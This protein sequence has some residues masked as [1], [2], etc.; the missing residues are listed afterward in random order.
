MIGTRH[1]LLKL[2]YRR[3]IW[4]VGGQLQ[5][6]VDYSSRS[7]E[8]H[9]GGPF[10]VPT[11]FGLFQGIFRLDLDGAAIFYHSTETLKQQ[12]K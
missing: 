2:A 6:F 4:S 9:I 12:F 3:A 5:R 1:A 7:D 8:L 11:D 10:E